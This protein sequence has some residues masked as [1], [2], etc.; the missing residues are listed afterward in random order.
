M[1]TLPE[2]EV[3]AVSIENLAGREFEGTIVSFFPERGW[4]FIDSPEVKEMGVPLQDGKKVFIHMNQVAD[5]SLR[6]KLSTLTDKN[7]TPNIKVVFKF[8]SNQRGLAA[9]DVREKGNTAP[10]LPDEVL[11]VDMLQAVYEEGEIEYYRRYEEIP[12]G[13]IRVKGNKLYRFDEEDAVDPVLAVFL[14]CS[15][16]AEGQK[17]KFIKSMGKRGKMKA[18]NVSASVPFPE[19]KLKDWER[20]GLIQ[21]AKERMGIKD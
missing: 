3:P 16:S 17:V 15:P 11:K 12:H 8:S 4:G 2:P 18:T 13:E 5:E 7:S 1:E 14:E 19:E 9:D 10:K 21:K 20:S 6:Y